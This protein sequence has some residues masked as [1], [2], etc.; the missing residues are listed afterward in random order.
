MQPMPK[1]GSTTANVSQAQARLNTG[2]NCHRH[3]RPIAINTQSYHGENEDI[4]Y[5]LVLQ[6]KK[7]DKKV[8]FQTFMEK[9][10]MYIVSNF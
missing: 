6:S 9:L 3:S 4:G 8:P 5:I 2:G 10:V 7:F 1:G